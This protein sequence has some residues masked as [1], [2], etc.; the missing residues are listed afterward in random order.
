MDK[1]YKI[2]FP[3]GKIYV[4]RTNDIDDRTA[5][6]RRSARNPAAS[7]DATFS[8][9]DIVILNKWPSIPS[10]RSTYSTILHAKQA[11][12]SLLID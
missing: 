7:A 3:N 10:Q 2:T 4:G 5:I 12:Q 11:S 8:I 1:I 9:F 6:K